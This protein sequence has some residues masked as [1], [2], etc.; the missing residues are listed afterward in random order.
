[1]MTGT[2]CYTFLRIPQFMC[3]DLHS[4]NLMT[5]AILSSFDVLGRQ[6]RSQGPAVHRCSRSTSCMVR[7]CP[8]VTAFDPVYQGD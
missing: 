2:Y 6:M 3:L 8:I 1:M 4:A 5:L 7:G